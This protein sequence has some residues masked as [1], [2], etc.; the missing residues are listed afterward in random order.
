MARTVSTSIFFP[1]LL[2]LR[3]LLVSFELHVVSWESAGS[4]WFFS[5]GVFSWLKAGIRFRAVWGHSRLFFFLR[6]KPFLLQRHFL[7]GFSCPPPLGQFF[8]AIPPFFFFSSP[9]TFSFLVFGRP[10]PGLP[11][12]ISSFGLLV[13]QSSSLSVRL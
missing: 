7:R 1:P 8:V 3:A 13:L 6:R 10:S 11:D 12:G 2:F 4:V 9:Q 5:L